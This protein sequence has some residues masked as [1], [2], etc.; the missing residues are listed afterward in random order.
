LFFSCY[1]QEQV[2]T[3]EVG[4]TCLPAGWIMSGMGLP[5]FGTSATSREELDVAVAD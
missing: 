3:L 2:A 5:I 1:L 4:T